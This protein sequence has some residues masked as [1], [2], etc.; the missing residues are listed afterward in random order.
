MY[1]MYTKTTSRLFQGSGLPGYPSTV[2]TLHFV[3]YRQRLTGY[4][5]PGPLSLF[6][7][8]SFFFILSMGHVYNQFT[9]TSGA[10]CTGC[11]LALALDR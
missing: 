6:F 10:Q 3:L 11:L 5:F 2:C 4:M 7:F 8:L 1:S 9:L